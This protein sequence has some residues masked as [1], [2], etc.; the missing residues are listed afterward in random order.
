MGLAAAAKMAAIMSWMIA[1][2]APASKQIK[3]AAESIRRRLRTQNVHAVSV[4][5]LVNA[6]PLRLPTVGR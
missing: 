5:V 3:L 1:S 2:G 4:G 6:E